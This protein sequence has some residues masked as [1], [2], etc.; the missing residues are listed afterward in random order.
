M[1]GGT[2][3][4]GVLHSRGTGLGVLV[5]RAVELDLD[6]RLRVVVTRACTCHGSHRGHLGPVLAEEA[7]LP[8]GG[9]PS[10]RDVPHICGGHV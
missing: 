8:V 3:S 6:D 5:G 1:P 10:F 9:D 4:G 7:A 2:Q